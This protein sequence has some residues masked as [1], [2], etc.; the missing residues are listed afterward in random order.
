MNNSKDII[1]KYTNFNNKK[2]HYIL[3]ENNNVI[4]ADLTTWAQFLGDEAERRI[5]NKQIIGELLIS[6]IFIGLDHNLALQE[7]KEDYKPHIFE[8]MIFKDN[9]DIYCDRYSTWKEAEEG[10]KEAVNWVNNGYKEEE[11]ND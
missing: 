11:E 2:D 6:T 10:H 8:T 1:N 7:E 5:V 4:E 3:D 9:K